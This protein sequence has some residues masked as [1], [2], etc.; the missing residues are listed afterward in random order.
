MTAEMKT[1]DLAIATLVSCRMMNVRVVQ[2]SSAAIAPASTGDA[3][4]ARVFF[5]GGGGGPLS[6]L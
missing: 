2:K 5:F 6:T 1:R 3:I 4:L